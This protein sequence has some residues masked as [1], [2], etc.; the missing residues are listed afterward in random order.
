M[1]LV[2]TKKPIANDTIKKEKK[3]NLKKGGNSPHISGQVQTLPKNAVKI[4]GHHWQ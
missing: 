1:I 2:H 4:T 3:E